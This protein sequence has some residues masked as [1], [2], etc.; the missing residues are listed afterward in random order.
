MNVYGQLKKAIIENTATDFTDMVKGF[1]WFNTTSNLI[2]YNNGS[3]SKTV[4]DTDSTQSLSNKTLT[5]PT[6]TGANFTLPSEIEPKKDTYAN[7]V[8]YALTSGDGKLCFSTDGKLFYFTSNNILNEVAVMKTIN[9]AVTNAQISV[10][11]TAVRCTVTGTAPNANR[12]RLIITPSAVNSGA[13]YFGGSNVT[14]STG[15]QIIGPDSIFLD[16]DASDYYLVSDT[17]SQLVAIVEVA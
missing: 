8:T 9:G 13:I 4:V 5:S 16:W 14:I 15:K 1:L 12:K 6:V 3:T 10:G 7:L 11:L 17:E 2:K